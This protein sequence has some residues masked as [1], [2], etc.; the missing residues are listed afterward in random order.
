MVKIWVTPASSNT[1][2]T[3]LDGTNVNFVP[4]A[5]AWGR[6]VSA[7]PSRHFAWRIATAWLTDVRPRRLL[8]ADVAVPC[9]D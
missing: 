1:R 6:Q 7:R 9:F 2:R 4:A 8:V 3:A 5:A